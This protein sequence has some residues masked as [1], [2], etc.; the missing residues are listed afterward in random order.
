MT[1]KE[2]IREIACIQADIV[3]RLS[4]SIGSDWRDLFKVAVNVMED[5]N[6]QIVAGT[7]ER[8]TKR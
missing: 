7:A 2:A 6:S 1:E 5:M 3:R 8:R 4:A